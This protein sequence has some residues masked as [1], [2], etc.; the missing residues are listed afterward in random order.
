M[1]FAGL[2]TQFIEA[3]EGEASSVQVFAMSIVCESIPQQRDR[4]RFISVVANYTIS[5]F[6]NVHVSQFDFQCNSG[7]WNSRSRVD[8]SDATFD[9]PVRRDCGACV[10]LTSSVISGPYDNITHCVRKYIGSGCMLITTCNVFNLF[11]SLLQFVTDVVDSINAAILQT[12][13]ATT[14]TMI[15]VLLSAHR[16]N[17]L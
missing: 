12:V 5:P 11:L 8:P 7:T 16:L 1:P 2:I 3:G 15:Y 6:S 13:V 17:R 10:Y 4:L 9:T 14:I